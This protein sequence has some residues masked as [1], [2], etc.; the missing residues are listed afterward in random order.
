MRS[1]LLLIPRLSPAYPP[2]MP[3]MARGESGGNAVETR[4]ISGGCAGQETD[5]IDKN[6]LINVK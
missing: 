5:R 1:V 6:M 2:P 3:R 4:G